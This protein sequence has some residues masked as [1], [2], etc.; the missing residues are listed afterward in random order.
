MRSWETI[1]TCAAGV[2]RAGL[3]SRGTAPGLLHLV[4]AHELEVL[5]E[6]LARGHLPAEF[7]AKLARLAG[8]DLMHQS[9]E[10]NCRLFVAMLLAAEEGTFGRAAKAERE[11]LLRVLAYVRKTDD[12]I[13]DYRPDGFSDDWVEVRAA[14]TELD[15]LI[16]SYKAW[17]L[18]HQVPQLWI[19]PGAG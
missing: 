18:R 5:R 6:A 11:R 7:Q 12:A 14:S 13:P 9:V 15:D 8:G 17:R 2:R 1:D 4:A 19:R 16:Q 3:D 10:R